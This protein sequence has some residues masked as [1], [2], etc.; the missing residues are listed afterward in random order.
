MDP[1]MLG[2]TGYEFW[3]R[4]KLKKGDWKNERREVVGNAAKPHGPNEN[5]DGEPREIRG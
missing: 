4:V 3:S 5:D 2:E 1:D